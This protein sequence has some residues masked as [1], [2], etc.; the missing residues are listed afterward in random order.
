MESEKRICQNCH[1]EFWI[2]PDDF[3]F[4]EM[5]KV[6][7]PKLCPD[8]RME[9]RLAFR[10][11]RTL[12]KRACDLCKKDGVSL[13]P[14]GTKF[15]VYCHKCWWSDGWD[16]VSF[17]INWDKSRPFFDQFLELKNK[18]PRIALL[19]IDSID[20]DY[21]NNSA[22]NKNCYLLFASENDEDCMYGRLIQRCKTSV[23]CT[24]L[25]DSELCY[26]CT[27]CKKCFKCLF[28]E[29]LQDCVDVLFSFDMRNC[30]NC[31]L[32]TNGRN[33]NYCIENKQCTKE[34][35]DRK[36]AE[37]LASHESIEGAKTR[38]N[39]LLG[40][41]IVKY[42]SSIKC[43]N[44]TGDYMYNCHDG[45]KI[46]DYGNSKN[47][48]Y[49]ADGEDAIDCQDCNNI[50]FKPERLYNV[51]AALQSSNCIV[52]IYDMYNN[53]SQYFDS[54]YN[55]QSVFGCCGLNKKNYFILNKEYS[56]EKYLEI[57]EEIIDQ[58]KR[59]GLYGEFF[60]AKH[61]PFGYNETL[62]QE[63]FP[64]TEKEAKERGFNWQNQTTG[65]YGK[66]TIKEENI[67]QTIAE[68]SDNI[69][70]EVLVCK[71]CKK[72]FRI[73]KGELDFYRRMNIPLP[74]KDFECRHQDR[75]K[76][77]NPRKL[78]HR[79]CMKPGCANEFE[80]S[81]APER[82]EIVYCEAC[83]NQEVA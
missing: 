22:E 50:Y 23:D 32:C 26:E 44:V 55:C 36:K 20:S 51:M 81:Y 75:M 77:R 27:D 2:E 66:E 41:T 67:P 31:I 57:R 56:K 48:S 34:E 70:N 52:G 13:Y 69:L 29:R 76:K 47:S 25:Y 39:E 4:Y 33:L 3:A 24:F 42:V 59:D 9:R 35:F 5:M 16:P 53:D 80:T 45:V 18:V 15:P 38:Y 37:I 6:P 49:I 12:Y 21:T 7:A 17:G 65:M 79:K 46:F 61:S 28:S 62:A 73:T 78:W 68:V 83:Y 14:S 10:N 58:L 74:H 72:N 1:S 11:E 71:D 64:I 8:C 60:P 63:Y 82:P 40:K 19:V 54:C 30:Q 43:N